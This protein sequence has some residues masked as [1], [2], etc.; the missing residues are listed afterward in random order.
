[1]SYRKYFLQESE[2]NSTDFK[3]IG[4]GKKI[5]RTW[6]YECCNVNGTIIN[7]NTT[8]LVKQGDGDNDVAI[9]HVLE[10]FKS[11]GKDPNRAKVLWFFTYK[12]LPTFY[13]NQI[14]SVDEKRELFTVLDETV[15][16]CIEEI[17]A[18]AIIGTCDVLQVYDGEIPLNVKKNQYFTRYGLE[19]H[20]KGLTV[21]YLEKPSAECKGEENI[22]VTKKEV[23]KTPKSAKKI[24]GK[25]S[26]SEPPKRK[27]I[28]RKPLEAL[29]TN[30]SNAASPKRKGSDSVYKEDTAPPDKIKKKTQVLKT[31]RPTPKEHSNRKSFTTEQLLHEVLD[32]EDEGNLSDVSLGSMS[33]TRSDASSRSSRSSKKKTAEKKV[34]EELANLGNTEISIVVKPCHNM[35]MTKALRRKSC[36]PSI[37]GAA[38]RNDAKN[39]DAKVNKLNILERPRR[40]VCK[41]PI[42]KKNCVLF[43]SS[44]D[45]QKS[46]LHTS[47]VTRSG[48]KSKVIYESLREK[49]VLK[50]DDNNKNKNGDD[51]D[52]DE[53]YTNEKTDEEVESEKGDDFVSEDEGGTSDSEEESDEEFALRKRKTRKRICMRAASSAKQKNHGSRKKSTNKTD[54]AMTPEISKRIQPR[55]EATSPLEFARKR[56]HVSTVPDSLPCREDEYDS[57]Y[58]FVQ[59]CLEEMTG[60]CMYISGVPGTGK[61]ATVH[62]V[63]RELG[64]KADK[65]DIPLFKFIE[66]NGMKLTEPNQTF[67][68]ILRDLTGQKATPDHAASILEKKFSQ[69]APKKENI[70]ILVDELDLL[71]TRKQN[72]M[73]NLFDWP[74]RR[75]SRL[76]VLAIANTM[77]L[78]ERIMMNRV[79]SRLGLTRLTFQPYTF[80]QL[81]EIVI[82]RIKGMD[83]FE[84]DALELVARK[85][86]ALSGDARRCLDICRRAVEIAE[87]EQEKPSVTTNVK[88]KTPRRKSVKSLS[89]GKKEASMKQL[90]SM[91]HVEI[92]LKEMFS[93]PKF[94]ALQSLSQMEE[95]FMKAVISEFRRSG[96]EEAQFNDVYDQFQSHCR[97]E[98]GFEPPNTSETFAICNSLGSF[99]LLLTEAGSKDILQRIRLNVSVDDVMFAFK[100]KAA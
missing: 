24:I 55:V 7:I 37:T 10:L 28:N 9:G 86:A 60:G 23:M 88:S 66:V 48:R 6:H 47:Y 83:A 58:A 35:N 22:K 43:T 64:S 92:A 21:K 72:V 5:K 85:V 18:E 99:R 51:D 33:S 69:P 75:H 50:E 52:A 40:S 38:A 57:I 32:E 74:T 46:N 73:Y 90:V 13:R 3:W 97:A 19:N 56:L 29:T 54:Q 17:D 31:D 71:W 14:E 82:S 39:E 41:T 65:G 15:Y 62:E 96:L 1:M 16:G 42:S 53:E 12:E 94:L 67:C 30:P 44:E 70:I 93:S 95:M 84:E 49:T 76:I 45:E 79:S 25:V 59:D 27:A 34:T 61:T 4:E 20:R 26:K 68:K 89:K 36:M 11:I 2:E 98:G 78:P 63:I 100:A 8:V 87:C 77:D 80:R 81:Q 91:K